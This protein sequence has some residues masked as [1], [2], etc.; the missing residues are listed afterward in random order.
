VSETVSP[1][2]P[3]LSASLRE[4][5]RST[6]ARS[7]VRRRLA[8]RVAVALCAVAVAVSLA[9]LVALV[10]YTTS[11]GIHALSVDFFTQSAPVANRGP[12]SRTPSWQPHHRGLA[13]LMAVPSG[14]RRRCSSWSAGA[15]LRGRSGS[16]P[17]SSPE[18]PPSP[19][20]SSP[21]PSSW[22]PS[23]TSRPWPA[24]SPWPSS[25]SRWSSG[26]ASRPCGPSPVRVGGGPG[27][28]G[29]AGPG[30]PVHRG[31]GGAARS[32]HRELLA[33]ARAVGETAP[34]LFTAIGSQLFNLTRASR[35]PTS[36]SRSTAT[37]PPPSPSISRRPGGG[38]RPARLRPYPECGA[39]LVADG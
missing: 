6:S 26:R 19:S 2:G 5:I 37:G 8:G 3:A 28:R 4:V 30:G 27:P 32:G 17:T 10:A 14:S 23:P 15:G 12:G 25:C 18:S 24:P 1:A 38:L 31:A 16:R 21:T 36:R 7:L 35:W 22:S 9:P 11:R 34:L 39:R 20:G 33:V 29:P 13:A